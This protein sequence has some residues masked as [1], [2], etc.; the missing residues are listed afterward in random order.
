VRISY[1]GRFYGAQTTGRNRRTGFRR[2]GPEEADECVNT[3]LLRQARE[4]NINLSQ[5]LE[6]R[7][8][9]R[10]LTERQHRWLDENQVA[11]EDY[12]GRVELEG[13]FSDGLRGF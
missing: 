2:F 3:D 10:I 11:I 7:L 5:A 12:N 13:V 9:E 4:L 8:V 1:A 6:E